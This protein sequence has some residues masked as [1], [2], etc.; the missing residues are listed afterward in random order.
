M[1]LKELLFSRFCSRLEKFGF[2]LEEAEKRF[3]NPGGVS[4]DA[5]ERAA[6]YI[7]D[8]LIL[9]G[10]SLPIEVQFGFPFTDILGAGNYDWADPDL[11]LVSKSLG[12]PW[13][14]QKIEGKTVNYFLGYNRLSKN[15]R[16][17][18]GGR[19][20]K[21]T[22][23]LI[24]FP[25]EPSNHEDGKLVIEELELRPALTEEVLALGAQHPELQKSF[26]IIGLG[27]RW[28]SYYS[29][30]KYGVRIYSEDGKRKAGFAN[31][32]LLSDTTITKNAR[33]LAI[34][35]RIH[36]SIISG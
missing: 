32:T 36:P 11:E 31:I 8:R 19:K 7:A 18:F 35:E 21:L 6:C 22:A 16:E 26:S 14:G 2:L 20:C 1:S 3:Q 4:E 28:E 27:E 23:W 12:E 5:I 33:Y 25:G 10:N 13:A 9:D 17:K 34:G 29:P 30:C 24:P 15:L